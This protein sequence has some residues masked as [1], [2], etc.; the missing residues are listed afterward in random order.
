MRLKICGATNPAEMRALA[1]LP[2]DFVGLWHGIPGGAADLSVPRL[3]D[4]AAMARNAGG[5]APVLVT[6]LGDAAALA[7][8]VA[9]TGIGWVQLHGFQSPAMV[10]ALREAAPDGTRIVKVLHVD[11]RTCLER[12]LIG[13]YE[14]AGVDLFLLDPLTADGRVGSTGQPLDPAVVLDLVSS[15]AQPFLLAGGLS[16]DNRGMFDAVVSHPLFFGIDVDSGARGADGAIAPD[17]VAAIARAWE[18]PASP[19]ETR[20]V[21][22]ETLLS[23]S[24]RVIAEIKA[25]T[26]DG[27]DL[28]R[29]RS[30]QDLVLAYQSAG[31]ACLSV[32]TG[33]WFGGTE[34]LLDEAVRDARVPVLKKDFITRADQIRSAA[35]RG[36]A[37]VLLT[38]KLLPGRALPKLVEAALEAG[39][40]PFV[41]VSTEA[42]IERLTLGPNGII[43][44]NNK[45]IE[46]RERG[47]ATLERSLA[48]LSLLRRTG[49][50]CPVS[51]SGLDTPDDAAR[52]LEA[53]YEGLL[54]GTGLLRA[55]SVVDWFAGLATRRSPHRVGLPRALEG[56]A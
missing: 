16:A 6:F 14:A 12:P 31:A 56:V 49:T 23:S 7:R 25:R 5:P 3:R 30:V 24:S 46:Q 17:R 10:R 15:L 27:T 4:L 28:L 2:V 38:A 21:F 42:E 53:G 47:A 18:V 35:D 51:A 54:V 9:E 37:A 22:I 29:G 13:A 43:A 19:N 32:V 26:S 52:M 33:A 8:V 34:D 1:T 11:G 50:C 40:T 48:L 20:G 36:A 45:D 44:V 39:V 41:E 55:A